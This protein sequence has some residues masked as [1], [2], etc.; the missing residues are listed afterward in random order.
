M[1]AKKKKA[2]KALIVIFQGMCFNYM[3]TLRIIKGTLGKYS[4]AEP[5]ALD[6]DA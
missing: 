6:K 2:I 5:I 4:Q 3:F 1:G